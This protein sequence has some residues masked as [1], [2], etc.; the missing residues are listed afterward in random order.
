MELQAGR[1]EGRRGWREG[2]AGSVTASSGACGVKIEGGAG[3]GAHRFRT[4]EPRHP[5]RQSFLS[6]L[7]H[8]ANQA[9]K[10]STTHTSPFHT[11]TRGYS[12]LASTNLGLATRQAYSTP[13]SSNTP[14]PTTLIIMG[15]TGPTR[16][17]LVS[18]ASTVSEHDVPTAPPSEANSR[19]GSPTQFPDSRPPSPG[20][21]AD[22]SRPPSPLLKAMGKLSMSKPGEERP[23]KPRRTSTADSTGSA[24]GSNGNGLARKPSLKGPKA[25]RGSSPALAPFLAKFEPHESYQGDKPEKVCVIGSGSWGTALARLA[26]QNAYELEGFDDEVNFWVR[27]RGR[28]SPP[29]YTTS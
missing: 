29:G 17:E 26:A 18:T 16:P 10:V 25:R 6:L 1:K 8:S 28:H 23:P 22:S 11:T 19:P 14:P 27:E 9:T 21:I 24:E 3:A 15:S 4:N 12:L 2:G 7:P 5:R 20:S 13:F